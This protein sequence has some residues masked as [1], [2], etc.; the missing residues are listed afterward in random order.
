MLHYLQS[1]LTFTSLPVIHSLVPSWPLWPH[2]FC[3]AH[4]QVLLICYCPKDGLGVFSAHSAFSDT[5]QASGY[6]YVQ[7]FHWIFYRQMWYSYTFHLHSKNSLP[8][9]FPGSNLMVLRNIFVAVIPYLSAAL[10]SLQISAI[11]PWMYKAF[12]CQTI[13]K[14]DLLSIFLLPVFTLVPFHWP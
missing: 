9:G 13:H 7:T 12:L 2:S 4:L 1:S 10:S 8:F 14:S 11:S 3:P 5:S 6:F